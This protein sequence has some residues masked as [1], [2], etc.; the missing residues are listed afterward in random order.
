MLIYMYTQ[1]MSL[2]WQARRDKRAPLDLYMHF[3]I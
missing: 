2:Q 1:I 3:S